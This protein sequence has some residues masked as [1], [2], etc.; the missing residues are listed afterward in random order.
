[1]GEN[2]ETSKLISH[3]EVQLVFFFFSPNNLTL[4][5]LPASWDIVMTSVHLPLMQGALVQIL[6]T[7]EVCTGNIP[8]LQCSGDKA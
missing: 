8:C 4:F 7:G 1:M 6:R 2:L 5:L 3:C